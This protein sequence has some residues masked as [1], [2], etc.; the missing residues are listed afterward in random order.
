MQDLW[1]L[2]SHLSRLLSG[3]SQTD[4]PV[5]GGSLSLWQSRRGVISQPVILIDLGTPGYWGWGCSDFHRKGLDGAGA[6][7]CSASASC[8]SAYFSVLHF[9]IKLEGTAFDL[10]VPK[11]KQCYR[12]IPLNL[13]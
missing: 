9:G 12:L 13:C 6:G 1:G 7:L 10:N 3:S 11:M 5:P 2:E 8:G 4:A